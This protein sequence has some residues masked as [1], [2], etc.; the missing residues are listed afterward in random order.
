[1]K[2]FFKQWV[3]SIDENVLQDA[4]FLLGIFVF[5]AVLVIGLFPSEGAEIFVGKDFFVYAVMTVPVVAAIYFIIISFRRNLYHGSISLGTSFK[6]KMVLAFVFVSIL[7][8]LPVIFAANNFIHQILERLAS[9]KTSQALQEG[10][11][12]SQQAASGVGEQIAAEIAST[13]LL[14][15]KHP[16]ENRESRELIADLYAPKNIQTFFLQ[17]SLIGSVDGRQETSLSELR[18]FYST[19]DLYKATGRQVDRL[20]INERDV[21]VGSL[22]TDRYIVSLVAPVPEISRRRAMLFN[23]SIEDFNRHRYFQEYFKNWGGVFLLS[24]S[25]VVIFI[26]ILISLYLSKNITRP[27]LELADASRHLA[28]GNFNVRLK[29]RSNDEI[30]LLMDSFNVMVAELDNNR[31][32]LYQKQVLEAWRDM[33]RRV[34]HEIK[35]PL[36]PIRLSAERM[37]KQYREKNPDFDAILKQGTETIIEEVD[38]LKNILSEFTKFARLPDMQPQWVSV[39]EL[40]EGA[41]AFY[42]S[43]QDVSFNVSVDSDLPAIYADKLLMKQA[44][45]NIINNAIDAVQG[46]GT[47]DIR[48]WKEDAQKLVVIS[49]SDN[50]VGVAPELAEEIFNPGFTQKTT[51]TGLGLSI[52]EKIIIEHRGRVFC[53]KNV[54]QGATFV[55]ELPIDLSEETLYG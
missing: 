18:L 27:V 21:V 5:F 3:D 12:M 51:G 41:V 55:I 14:L 25:I 1:M 15:K 23:N 22:F 2:L 35:N 54:D 17:K 7:A 40:L 32:L 47:V 34:V 42:S 37:R 11:A 24:I 28:T 13:E 29:R 36:T 10:F 53:Q 49:I 19:L 31:K 16:I 39:A 52:V 8:S 30:G 4:I 20:H 6:N 26:S 43:Y 9:E 48:A 46:M 33:A 38:V 45:N 50:G 44:L